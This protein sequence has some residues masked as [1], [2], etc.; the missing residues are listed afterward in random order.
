MSHEQI[1]LIVKRDGTVV[2]Q[3]TGY[4]GPACKAATK[5]IEAALGDVVDEQ[6]SP[7]WYATQ[8]SGMQQR[9]GH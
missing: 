3:P 7:E 5:A 4:S 1:T 2:V 8:K 6:R 9:I